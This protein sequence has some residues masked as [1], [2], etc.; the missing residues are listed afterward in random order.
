VNDLLRGSLPKVPA[1]RK[2]ALITVVGDVGIGIEPSAG[3]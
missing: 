2:E 1:E 3:R